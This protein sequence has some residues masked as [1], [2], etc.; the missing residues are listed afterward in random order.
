[1]SP[2][3]TGAI[4]ILSDIDGEPVQADVQVIVVGQ[5]SLKDGSPI[6]VVDEAF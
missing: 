6:T 3:T 4:E 1:M 2:L 5:E